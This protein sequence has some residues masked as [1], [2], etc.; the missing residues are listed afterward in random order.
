MTLPVP[1]GHIAP[2]AEVSALPAPRTLRIFRRMAPVVRASV[3]AA[4]AGLGVELALRAVASRALATLGRGE[5][6]VAKA[7]VG[8]T[9]IVV[10]EFVI[11]ER[12]RRFR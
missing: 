6:G 9:R 7:A 8:T 3:V 1:Q 10:T 12:V 11:R 5:V 2:R 4:A